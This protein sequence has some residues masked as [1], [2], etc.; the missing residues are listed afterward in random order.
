MSDF[1]ANNRVFDLHIFLIATDKSK[2]S[3]LN[4][5]YLS[6]THANTRVKTPLY[7]SNLYRKRILQN[8]SITMYLFPLKKENVMFEN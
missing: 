8:F 6:S 7:N 3:K 5:S 4:T 2:N 1:V